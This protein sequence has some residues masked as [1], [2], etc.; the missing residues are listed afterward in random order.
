MTRGPATVGSVVY[1]WQRPTC[2]GSGPMKQIKRVPAEE[3]AKHAAEYFE[4]HEAVSIEKDGEVIGRYIPM[5]NG[6]SANGTGA[7]PRPVK[8]KAE[9]RV[10]ERIGHDGEK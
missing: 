6:Q 9:L 1:W 10:C 8:P 4:G 2:P 7:R 3:F 5:P